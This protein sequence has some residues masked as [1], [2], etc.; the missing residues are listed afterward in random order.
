MS[1]ENPVL[2]F[3]RI[4]IQELWSIRDARAFDLRAG[5]LRIP[6]KRIVERYTTVRGHGRLRV[7]VEQQEGRVVK[8]GAE[9]V[10]ACRQ[11]LS[12]PDRY[13]G[14]GKLTK[15]GYFAVGSFRQARCAPPHRAQAWNT[16]C[17]PADLWDITGR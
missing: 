10:D 17:P 7:I 5:V 4:T 14:G 2:G 15:F 3:A 16:R 12:H 6:P 1:R 11:Y 8:L 9:A 13:H